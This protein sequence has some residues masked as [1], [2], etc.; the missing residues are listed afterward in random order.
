MNADNGII[1][2]LTPPILLITH[3]HHHY[4]STHMNTHLKISLIYQSVYAPPLL[5]G[6]LLVPSSSFPSIAHKS[7]NPAGKSRH[8]TPSNS[9]HTIHLTELDRAII[10]CVLIA[11]FS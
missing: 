9:D 5:L 7:K 2:N 1:S 8:L 4:S 3:K 6:A 11:E 10:T